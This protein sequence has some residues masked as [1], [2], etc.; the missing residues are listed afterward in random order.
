LSEG[1]LDL[2]E[3]SGATRW[4]RDAERLL[5]R[6]LL[7]FADE[8][9]G[10]LY[11]TARGHEKLIMRY[12]DG[13]DGATPAG[14]AVAA[15]TLAR[16]S[17]H[18]DRKELLHAAV[19]AI[20][21][22]GPGISRYPR[23]FAKSLMAVEL[24]LEGPVELAFVGARGSSDLEALK[25]EVARHFLPNRI[26]ADLDSQQPGEAAT[27]PLLEGKAVVGGA[28][29]LYVCRDFTCQAPVTEP[30]AVAGALELHSL[31]E[32]E[33]QSTIAIHLP[34]RATAA[35][36]AR[37]SSRFGQTGYTKL[38]RTDLTV[39]R[40]GFGGY[41][42]HDRDP[43][44]REA[45]RK[46]LLSGVNLIDTS[47][48]YV[49]GGSE[50]LVGSVLREMIDAGELGRDEIIVVS[51]IGYLQATTLE[52]AR[53]LEDSGSPY[54][55][56]VRYEEGLWHCI[57][58][59]FLDDQLRRSLDRLEL[60]T[61]DFVLLHNPEYFL[62]AAARAGEPRDAARDEFYRRLQS[63]FAFMEE[64]VLDGRIAGYGISSN[65]VV[66]PT[67]ETDETS[68]NRMSDAARAAAGDDHHFHILQAPLNLLEPGA[69]TERKEGSSGDQTVLE[70]ASDEG[71]AVLVNRPLNAFVS[72][73]LLRLAD[74][75]P[76]NIDIDFDEQLGRVADLEFA[77][78]TEIA[79]KLQAAPDALDPGEYF[80]L[81][82]RLKEIQP[83]ITGIAHWSQ[84][85]A[86][87]NMTVMAVVGVLNRQLEGDLRDRWVEWRDSY[88]PE[89]EDLRRVLRQQAAELTK[90]TNMELTDA[91]DPLLPEARRA[92]SLSRKALWILMSTPGVTSVLNGM[93]RPEQVA[94]STTVPS[95]PALESVKELFDAVK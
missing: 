66:S 72:G 90:T 30:G 61:L 59:E 95:W 75:K 48:N 44:H 3:A 7:D 22:Y 5:D 49:D 82:Q 41:R 32:V 10:A 58:P 25:R 24:L 1:L 12:R 76:E 34:G 23:G 42:V 56:M 15:L 80:R 28:A 4:L 39:S 43:Q 52:T 6:T 88:L 18:L 78:S 55:E 93:R 20:K 29:A 71:I 16:L 57:H 9:T 73:R 86:Q 33:P 11:N 85:E 87:V 19:R 8:E 74:V 62:S 21:A 67:S 38:G 46:A 89:L 2:Y 31:A 26:Q 94:D 36:T 64:Q 81:S 40:L 45:L 60:E 79:P 83:A 51:K 68:L 37:Y 14:N 65:T 13:A 47:T 35:G 84:V 50:R 91:I 27:L 92:E 70:A 17:Y 54:P 77:F 53:E 63:A 69:V